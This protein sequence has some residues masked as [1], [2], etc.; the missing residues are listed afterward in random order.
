[1]LSYR[2]CF[3]HAI[4]HGWKALDPAAREEV[5]QLALAVLSLA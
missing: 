2:E 3:Q 4:A 1:M 5:L